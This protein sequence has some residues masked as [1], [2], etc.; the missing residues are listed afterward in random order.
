MIE[1]HRTTERKLIQDIS[2]AL[3]S[4]GIPHELTAHGRV[5]AVLVAES[6]ADRALTEV[7]ACLDETEQDQSAAPPAPPPRR[8]RAWPGAAGYLV[9]LFAFYTLQHSGAFGLDWLGAG[10]THG[11][12]VRAGELWRPLTAL[13][14]HSG[15]AHLLGNAAL[16]ALL[17][18]LFARTVGTGV[19]WSTIALSG[20]LGNFANAYLRGAER[21]SIGASTAVFGALGALAAWQWAFARPA[22]HRLLHRWAPIVGGLVLLGFLGMSTE[23]RVDV[24]AHATGFAAGLVVALASSWWTVRREAPPAVERLL[25]VAPLAAIAAA[26]VFALRGS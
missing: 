3:T 21:S 16:G 18:G 12:S 26:W 8:A 4:A 24:L 7:A 5:H 2:L 20:F 11:G 13:T 1:V 10:R 14:L 15:M 9:V 19:A 23:E 6:D 22:R 17:G 25:R